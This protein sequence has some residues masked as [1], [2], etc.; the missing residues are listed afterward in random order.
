MNSVY[1]FRNPTKDTIQWGFF[2]LLFID[3]SVS[4]SFSFFFFTKK[5]QNWFFT[6]YIL[7]VS[8]DTDE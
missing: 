5:D 8:N 6:P 3:P 1:E 4:V 2:L 7:D